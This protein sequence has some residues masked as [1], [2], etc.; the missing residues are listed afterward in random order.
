MS[1]T[2]SVDP[3]EKVELYPIDFRDGLEPLHRRV[4]HEGIRG[5][6]IRRRRR[7]RYRPLDQF[8]QLVE[9]FGDGVEVVVGQG[10]FLNRRGSALTITRCANCTLHGRCALSTLVVS[11]K[12]VSIL[13]AR[14]RRLTRNTAPLVPRP[15][16][17]PDKSGHWQAS[18]RRPKGRFAQ[19][20]RAPLV[21]EHARVPISF[22]KKPRLAIVRAAWPPGSSQGPIVPKGWS[23]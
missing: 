14:S 18:R 5:R 12:R 3:L 17:A 21:R 9:T 23:T 19:K 16:G 7:D 20:E 8:D 15:A 4:P 2:D 1:P 11:M 10:G 13:A 6:K 22:A